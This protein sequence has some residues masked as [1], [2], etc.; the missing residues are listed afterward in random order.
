MLIGK[1]KLQMLKKALCLIFAFLFSIN[2]FAAVVS[3]SDGSAFVTKAE[4]EALKK[5]FDNQIDNYNASIDNKI[6][7]SIA[8]YLSGIKQAK[9]ESVNTGFDIVGKEKLVTFYGKTNIYPNSNNEPYVN[10]NVFCLICSAYTDSDFWTEDMQHV[11][12][13][14]GTFTDGN[15]SNSVFDLQ[16]DYIKGVFKRNRVDM[17]IQGSGYGASSDIFHYGG[18]W[19]LLKM[20]INRLTEAQLNGN[21]DR[22]TWPFSI[23]TSAYGFENY[24]THRSYSQKGWSHHSDTI[25]FRADTGPACVWYSDAVDATSITRCGAATINCNWSYDN[26]DKMNAHWPWGASQTMKIKPVVYDSSGNI[27]KD[28]NYIWANNR[29]YTTN[30]IVNSRTGTAFDANLNNGD[31]TTWPFTCETITGYVP[32]LNTSS[33]SINN[34]KY[35]DLYNIIGRDEKVSNGFF[36]IS[37]ENRQEGELIITLNSNTDDTYVFFSSAN[38]GSSIDSTNNLELEIEDETT[39]IITKGTE[40]HLVSRNKNY[41]IKVSFYANDRQIYIGVAGPS[42]NIDNFEISLTQIGDAILEI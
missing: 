17:A 13:A 29:T 15:L 23:S 1:K 42:K 30:V 41:K 34:Y 37:N 12:A 36:V 3:D 21:Y 38:F 14:N 5:D 22:N 6:D 18:L 7:G 8:A 33:R 19:A 25:G 35:Y 24:A 28:S 20:T 9:K 10:S 39:G 16:D 31:N 11:V 26:E 32:Y 27:T 4:F 2:S 40:A